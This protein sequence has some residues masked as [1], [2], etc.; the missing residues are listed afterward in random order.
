M[1]RRTFVQAASCA[2]AGAALA[3]IDVW[4]RDGRALHDDVILGHGDFQY[5]LD[6]DWGRLDPTRVPVRDCHEM[7]QDS[8]GR[9]VLLTNHTDNNVIVYDRGGRLL[10]TW[11]TEYPGAHGLTLSV[12][13]G[14]DFLFIADNQ[15]HEVIKTTIDGRV[16][17]TMPYPEDCPAYTSPEQYIPTEVAIGPNG[18][19]YV[20]DGYGSQYVIQ[21]SATGEYIRCFGGRGDGP[22]SLANA[23]GVC[24]DDRDPDRP[25]LLV[26]AREQNA[27]KRFSLDGRYLETIELPGAYVCRPVIHGQN[28]YAAVLVSRMPW[29]SRSGFV[30]I[31]DRDD[32]VVS[33][34]G[35]SVPDYTDGD[36]APMHQVVKVF[37]HPH[38]VCVDDDENLYVAQWNSD[39]I[40]PIKL[41]RIA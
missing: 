20:A 6:Y 19:I 28:I 13:G 25:T 4:G 23:H 22:D 35:G 12:E 30:T 10:E 1:K 24:L 33:N 9:I 14:E 27:F 26:T 40:Y 41:E 21:Y 18:D 37:R 16:I 15:R 8:R 11:G 29:D 7:V 36:L 34:P 17:L 5:R 38:D 2:A 31:L 39:G 32:R 3:P